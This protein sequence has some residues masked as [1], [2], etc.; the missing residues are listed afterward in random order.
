MPKSKKKQSKPKA[1]LLQSIEKTLTGIK[2]FD[3]ISFGGIPRARPTLIC[4]NAGC[5]KT[6]MALEILVR[7]AVEY[8]EPGVFLAFEETREDLIKNVASL[9]FDLKDLEKRKLLLIDYIY[10]D[11][12]GLTQTGDYDLEALFIRI[13]YS[14][15]SIGAKRLAID[16][17]DILFS[18]FPNDFIL[19]S[20][21]R[22]LFRWLKEKKLTTIVTGESGEGVSLTRHG[23]EEYVADCVIFLTSR[24]SEEMFTRRL[25]IIKYRGSYH[26]T[27]EF[28]FLITRHGISVLP[29]TTPDM[30]S[31][32]S[33]KRVSTGVSELDQILGGNGFFEG[34][35]ILLSGTSGTG[36]TTFATT[37]AH[38]ICLSK[39]RCLYFSYEESED[40][41]IRN[42]DSMGI[43]LAKQIKAG[44]LKIISAR[45]TQ[46]GLE[47]HLEDFLEEVE[48]FKPHAVVLDP[49]STL[50]H[51]GS[52]QQ[53]YG[54]L[55]R[56]IDY[57]KN[58]QITLFMTILFALEAGKEFSYGISSII[59]A[60]ILLRNEELNG[61][62]NRSLRIVK[63][64]GMDH[65]NQIREFSMTNKGLIFKELYLGGWEMLTGTARMAQEN[66][67]L[68]EKAENMNTIR[69]LHNEVFL[70]KQL[71][72]SQIDA[73]NAE[74]EAKKREVLEKEKL[75]LQ[76]E[77]KTHDDLTA[78]RKSVHSSSKINTQ[79]AVK[80]NKRRKRV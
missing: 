15:K 8:N 19:R 68:D 13:E 66:K 17:M 41:I 32:A 14:V 26:E 60:W 10:V 76:K 3:E 11:I 44:R 47:K 37:F 2:G 31:K 9:G 24:K 34:S 36:K 25:Q 55:M 59:D 50:T 79:R 23:I 20:E 77:K 62:L 18:G 46:K 53:V 74:F 4:G 7:G 73:L 56:I 29:I 16:T 30:G 58:Q 69:K 57:L 27:N 21:L 71:V 6:L 38:S 33:R 5:G 1:S 51:C 80:N 70:K 52:E 63:S 43:D 61:E 12:A 67:D 65:T 40:E 78:A 42:L 64:R 48:Q 45:P 49:V 28:P 22:R 39:Q 54:V 72:N 75:L 35:S